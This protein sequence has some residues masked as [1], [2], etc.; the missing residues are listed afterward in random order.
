MS[1]AMPLSDIRA[2][3]LKPRV[4]AYISLNFKVCS[5][6]ISLTVLSF[7]NLNTGFMAKNGCILLAFIPM[8]ALLT[9]ARL[10]TMRAL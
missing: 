5:S 9:L 10:K 3:S 1:T 7:G 4:N 8:L 6:T 2:R